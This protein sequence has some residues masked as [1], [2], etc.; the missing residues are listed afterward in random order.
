MQHA[1]FLKDH[2]SS[3]IEKGKE[4]QTERRRQYMS[5]EMISK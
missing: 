2:V 5:G 4:N 3:S 1:F